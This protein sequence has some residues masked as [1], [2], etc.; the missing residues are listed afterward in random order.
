MMQCLFSGQTTYLYNLSVVLPQNGTTP[1]S[2]AVPFWGQT[3]WTLSD[4]SPKRDCGSKRVKEH[5]SRKRWLILD[6]K[7]KSID[8]IFPQTFICMQA[9]FRSPRCREGDK[10][11]KIRG[12]GV[13]LSHVW[14]WGTVTTCVE[15]YARCLVHTLYYGGASYVV[16]RT[17]GTAHIK[18]T[19][20]LPI[21]TNYI[22]SYLLW[23]PVILCQRE[24]PNDTYFLGTCYQA[25]YTSIC[26]FVAGIYSKNTTASC[27]V[28]SRVW[29]KL[30]Y[31]CKLSATLRSRVLPTGF[32]W[33]NAGRAV[34]LYIYIYIP[35]IY[36]IYIYTFLYIYI[37]VYKSI[38]GIYY[39]YIYVYK[40]I[41]G[42]LYIYI[43]VYIYEKDRFETAE[44]NEWVCLYFGI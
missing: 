8:E 43:Y 24:V 23:S 6:S 9:F 5:N 29:S 12:G 38:P 7:K 28:R 41:P 3:A 16:D 32:T 20:D 27:W 4:L 35:G 39:I 2:T 19:I 33:S 40:S 11:L 22:W 15:R 36:I 37:Y 25:V 14:S 17:C 34:R 31:L 1:F 13:M 10:A 26:T 44:F 21:F 18:P 30:I 42:I